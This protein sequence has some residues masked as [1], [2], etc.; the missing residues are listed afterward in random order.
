[1]YLYMYRVA[2][3]HKVSE[4]IIINQKY[5]SVYIDRISSNILLKHFSNR[6][7]GRGNTGGST[8]STGSTQAH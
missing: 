7:S 8:G 2:K 1:L 6:K 4:K 3:L 5:C